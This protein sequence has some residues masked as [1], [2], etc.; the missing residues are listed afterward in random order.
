MRQMEQHFTQRKR[1]RLKGV[2]YNANGAYFITICTKDRQ[3]L[4]WLSNHPDTSDPVG[5]ALRRPSYIPDSY[6]APS[7]PVGAALRRPSYIP[8]SYSAPSDPV[9]AAL[10]R[11]SYIPDSYSAPFDPVGAALRRPPERLNENGE[12]VL[13]EIGKFDAIYQGIVTVDNFV[14]MPNHVHLLLSIHTEKLGGRRNAAPTISSVVN[15]FKGCVSKGI[16]FPCW[17]K[18]F[19]DHIVRDERD[20]RLIWEYI[21]ANPGKWEEDRYFIPVDG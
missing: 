21:D 16:G 6:S 9:G 14:I 17:Q 18:S 2:Y 12:I 5:A 20:Y 15:Q 3:N 7:D 4:F 19:H 1:N 8:D 11:P 10:R 13:R